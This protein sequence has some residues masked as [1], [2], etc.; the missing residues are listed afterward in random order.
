MWVHFRLEEELALCTFTTL[1]GI[2]WGV[3]EGPNVVS[4]VLSSTWSLP[5]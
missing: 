5:V 3:Y 1:E 4:S 2:L